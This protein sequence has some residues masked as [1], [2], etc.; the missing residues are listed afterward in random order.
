[1][2][3]RVERHQSPNREGSRNGS[4]QAFDAIFVPNPTA[5]EIL[6]LNDAAMAVFKKLIEIVWIRLK[7]CSGH[8]L[9]FLL[10][11]RLAG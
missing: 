1:M 4:D 7:R 6:Q 11:C 5:L 10:C 8:A 2:G 3:S 9:M